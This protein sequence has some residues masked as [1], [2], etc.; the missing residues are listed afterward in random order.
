M[1]VI[2]GR[3]RGRTLTAL[4]GQTTRPT[5]DRV[6][7]AMMSA[8]ISARGPFEGACVL[9]AFAGSGALGI[10]ALSRGAAC[11]VFCEQYAGALR[12]VKENVSTLAIPH[13]QAVVV[14]GDV[15]SVIERLS[16]YVFDVVFLDPPYKTDPREVLEFCERCAIA[17]IL[18]PASIVCYE[19]AHDAH[20]DVLALVD[21]LQWELVS[22][23]NYGQTSLVL[24]RR[25]KL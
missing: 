13:E 1:R 17:G 18:H 9:D 7:E 25:E 6:K 12:V 23:K 15:L 10:E 24:L 16:A 22:D 4:K 5:T 21:T 2:A 8:I 11:A 3:Y 14:R 20:P 19:H